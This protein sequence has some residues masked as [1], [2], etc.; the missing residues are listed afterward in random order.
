MK[1]LNY[2]AFKEFSDRV[3]FEELYERYRLKKELITEDISKLL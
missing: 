1:V 3:P 2:G